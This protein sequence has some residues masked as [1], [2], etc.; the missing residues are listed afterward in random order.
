M[1]TERFL[2]TGELRIRV[3]FGPEHGPPVL[4]L[5]GVSRVGRDF[6]P[7]F[8][9]LR[10]LAGI[11]RSVKELARDLADIQL[12]QP[13]VESVRLGDV[14]DAAALRFSAR[15]LPLLDRAVFDPVLDGTWFRGYEEDAIW[16]AIKCP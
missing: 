10:K 12:T 13:G 5:H 4:F 7:L 16:R 9:A 2:E 8:P 6:A 3:I 1:F 15:C 14:R 11:E